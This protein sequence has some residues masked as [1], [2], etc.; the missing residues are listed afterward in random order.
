MFSTALSKPQGTTRFSNVIY[1]VTLAIAVLVLVPIADF[2]FDHAARTQNAD[3][4]R[5]A[6][7]VA[8]L[9]API[10]LTFGAI[11]LFLRSGGTLWVYGIFWITTFVPRLLSRAGHAEP[12][13][14][15]VVAVIILLVLTITLVYLVWHNELRAP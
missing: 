4:A 15:I 12:Y 9:E 11:A 2:S 8:S 13:L 10:L 7:Y 1:W 3:L 6:F 14:V 5:F